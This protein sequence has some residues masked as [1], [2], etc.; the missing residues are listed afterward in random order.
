MEWTQNAAIRSLIG[1]PDIVR[2]ESAWRQI[3][4]ILS[5]LAKF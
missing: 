3:A 5:K 1:G 4:Q 2:R